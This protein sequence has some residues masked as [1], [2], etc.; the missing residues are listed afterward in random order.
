M[1][2]G[3]SDFTGVFSFYQTKYIVVCKHRWMSTIG[4]LV[5]IAWKTRAV[6]ECTALKPTPT[7]SQPIAHFHRTKPMV[8]RRLSVQNPQPYGRYSLAP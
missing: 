5:H 6:I 1:A 2:A 3:M 4:P 8:R 7:Q